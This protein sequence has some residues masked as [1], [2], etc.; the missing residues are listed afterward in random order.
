[1]LR[2]SF[3][4]FIAGLFH[5]KLKKMSDELFQSFFVKS[6]ENQK[7]LQSKIAA[8]HNDKINLEREV[9]RCNSIIISNSKDI[10]ELRDE[11][12]RHRELLQQSSDEAENVSKKLKQTESNLDYE[13]KENDKL[14]KDNS[15]KASLIKRLENVSASRKT[16]I[17]NLTKDIVSLNMEKKRM[18]KRIE[19]LESEMETKI[20]L[21]KDLQEKVADLEQRY[22]AI[23]VT[24][25]NHASDEIDTLTRTIEDLKSAN[26]ELFRTV[27]TLRD[28]NLF[29]NDDI[30]KLR[31]KLEEKEKSFEDLDLENVELTK[32]LESLNRQNVEFA[33][34][35]EGI[36]SQLEE[37]RQAAKGLKDENLCLKDEVKHLQES[38]ESVE[39][40]RQTLKAQE[41]QTRI[42]EAKV[43]LREA[44]IQILQDKLDSTDR[45]SSGLFEKEKEINELLA[46]NQNLLVKNLQQI[47]KIEEL[48]AKVCEFET[49]QV[50]LEKVKNIRMD[51]E[52]QIGSKDHQILE[53]SEEISNLC[54]LEPETRKRPRKDFEY[55]KMRELEMKVKEISDARDLMLEENIKQ[56][57][58]IE[59]LTNQLSKA[60]K[61]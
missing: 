22:D 40:L 18:K 32:K 26:H 16:E 6:N 25:L 43:R 50:E 9:D 31:K 33:K 60:Q 12:G 2:F 24:S 7:S 34:N 51:L 17:D 27:E 56:M 28:S 58:R 23:N 54:S 19:S 1:M 53:L 4:Q 49:L 41:E 48:N 30:V 35:V 45:N 13:R 39:N 29:Y 55:E 11:L 52:K 10:K 14:T 61:K 57:D 38:L 36:L 37:Q 8:V 15:K 42:C 47:Q 46:E 3:L 20:K 59:E 5:L 21:E 44:K